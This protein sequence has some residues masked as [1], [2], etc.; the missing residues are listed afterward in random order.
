V[1]PAG[2]AAS[3]GSQFAVSRLIA[4]KRKA[5]FGQPAPE[6]PPA[7]RIAGACKKARQWPR[8]RV[9]AWYPCSLRNSFLIVNPLTQGTRMRLNAAPL[10]PTGSLILR[11]L[12]ENSFRLP[13]FFARTPLHG[14]RA[15]RSEATPPKAHENFPNTLGRLGIE[16]R[17][18]APG[19]AVA[20]LCSLP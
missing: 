16:H 15:A 17:Y 8:K 10:Q 12:Q 1:S 2:S 3:T 19:N 14:P 7:T 9:H 4:R 13:Y 6:P 20:K 11:F 18:Q 5:S